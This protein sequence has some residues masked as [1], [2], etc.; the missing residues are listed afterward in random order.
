MLTEGITLGLKH[1]QESKMPVLIAAGA[2]KAAIIAEAM[3][4]GVTNRLPASIFQTLPQ[5]VIIL[6]EAAASGL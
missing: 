5:A 2:K 4:G 3:K 6:D 1:L